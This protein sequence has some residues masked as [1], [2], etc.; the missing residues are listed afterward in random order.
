MTYLYMSDKMTLQMYTGKCKWETQKTIKIKT[1]MRSSHRP[2]VPA[3]QVHSRAMVSP[4][5]ERNKDSVGHTIGNYLGD[6]DN[7]PG[8]AGGPQASGTLR[9]GHLV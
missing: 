4:W 5:K 7:S 1:Q 6:R 2:G 3:P 8:K 9:R